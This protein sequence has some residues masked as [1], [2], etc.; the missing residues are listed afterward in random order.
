VSSLLKKIDNPFPSRATMLKN[1]ARLLTELC[2]EDLAS[3]QMDLPAEPVLAPAPTPALVPAINPLHGTII[4]HKQA[5]DFVIPRRTTMSPPPA[6]VK[7]SPLPALSIPA[8]NFWI[9]RASTPIEDLSP[10]SPLG[11]PV[12]TATSGTMP[13]DYVNFRRPADPP[14]SLASTTCLAPSV[15]SPFSRP[16]QGF[17]TCGSLV[18]ESI[19]PTDSISN[20]GS[21]HGSS[22]SSEG[23]THSSASTCSTA[24]NPTQAYPGLESS[25]LT[26]LYRAMPKISSGRVATPG[27]NAIWYNMRGYARSGDAEWP[28]AD[29]VEKHWAPESSPAFCPPK[30]PRQLPADASLTRS[31]PRAVKRMKSYAAPAHLVADLMDGLSEG[32]FV[33]LARAASLNSDP[34]VQHHLAEVHSFLTGQASYQLGLAV[35]SLAASYNVIASERKASLLRSQS[36]EV[37]RAL[38][39][40]KPGFDKFFSGDVDQILSVATQASQLALTQATI[41]SLTKLSNSQRYSSGG[42]APNKFG[43]NRYQPY[44]P[45]SNNNK[46]WGNNNNKRDADK[47]SN[48]HAN[49]GRNNYKRDN[50]NSQRKP[51]NK[52]FNSNFK[53]GGK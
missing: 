41:S 12:A 50:A 5:D 16:P 39:D 43:K 18:C 10:M 17:E 22:H 35:R 46:S 24:V 49:S 27:T 42:K 36:S 2:A 21:S 52:K 29:Q 28:K 15:V 32:A 53:K 48:D 40:V 51:Y 8:E 38:T 6:V 26:G 1:V 7:A 34:A 20:V 25:L 47:S 3:V 19:G 14:R 4:T 11:S 45:N 23:A 9:P 33:P 31:D 44:K 37:K 13:D 30:L